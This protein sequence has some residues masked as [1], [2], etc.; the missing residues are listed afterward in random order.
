MPQHYPFTA[1]VGAE[2]D[3]L[4]DDIGSAAAYLDDFGLRKGDRMALLAGNSAEFII[5]AH[6]ASRKWYAIAASGNGLPRARPRR[7]RQCSRACGW[8]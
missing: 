7:A 6:A 2:P 4:D 5:A 3:Q 8:R 1:V